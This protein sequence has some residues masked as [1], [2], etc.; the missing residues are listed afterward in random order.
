MLYSPVILCFI[1]INLGLTKAW[2]RYQFQYNKVIY[3]VTGS[4][5]GGDVLPGAI[6]NLP[7]LCESWLLRGTGIHGALDIPRHA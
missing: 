1:V 5:N 4:N 7:Q 3:A 2:A 6:R